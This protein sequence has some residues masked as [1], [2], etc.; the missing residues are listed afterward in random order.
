MKIAITGTHGT[1]KTTLARALAAKTGLP[2]I[3]EQARVVAAEMGLTNC[4]QLLNSPERAKAFQERVLER[5]IA[6][7][8]KH[9]EG[10]IADRSTLDAIAYWKL[11][12]GNTKSQVSPGTK[13]DRYIYKARLHA[14]KGLDLLVYIPPV[15]LG[16]EDEFRLKGHHIE[17]D[18]F[19]QQEVKL[20]RESGRVQVVV[21][22][23][24]TLDER[25][26]EVEQAIGRLAAAANMGYAHTR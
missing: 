10:F 2:L 20:L 1:G 17:V 22:K 24:K 4:N 7:Q 11:Y 3:V 13:T 8:I 14:W 23:S 9:P 25:L 6:E 21:L 5:Q 15:I 16:G 18:L 19:I 26:A 12:L